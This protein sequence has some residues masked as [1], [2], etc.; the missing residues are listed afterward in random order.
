MLRQFGHELRRPQAD[1]LR[2]G[3]CEL[4][5]KRGR[6]NYRLLYFFHGRDVAVLAHSLTK[7]REVPA[8]DIERAI[9]RK[10]RFQK[11]PDAHTYQGGLEP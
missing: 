6:V 1:L 11:A 5:A 7:E 4:R 8:A 9:A 10:V 2:D 3:I